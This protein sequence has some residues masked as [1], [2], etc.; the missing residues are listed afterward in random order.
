VLPAGQSARTRFSVPLAACLV[1]LCGIGLATMLVSGRQEIVPDRT[2]FT[3]FPTKFGD[4]TG[5]TSSMEPEVEHFL[6]LTDYI[7][8][9]YRQSDGR[10]VNLYVAYY[11]SQRKGQAP[12]SPSVCIP[13]GGWQISRFDRTRYTST[14]PAMTLPFNRVV[15]EKDMHKLIVYYWFEQR[16]R[17]VENEWLSK[18]Y[19][20]ADAISKNRTDGA[21]VRL[22]TAVYPGEPEE[23]A[24]KRLQSF[25]GDVVP[26]LAGFL[27]AEVPGSASPV[28]SSIK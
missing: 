9:D 20:L 13:G 12:H 3:Q 18:W 22:T 16:G 4:W 17:K 7:L 19:L 24:D 28:L 10:S 21:L 23:N 25:I 5:R 6:G 26:Q 8:S 11:E 2:N 1:L 15:I 14:N 27:P